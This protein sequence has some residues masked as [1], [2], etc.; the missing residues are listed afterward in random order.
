M[1]VYSWTSAFLLDVHR[2]WRDD[3]DIF[4]HASSDRIGRVRS[5]R[6]RSLELNPGHGEDRQ[7]DTFIL[8]LRYHDPDHWQDG[9]WDTFILPLSYHD[10]GHGEDRQW[11]TFILPLSYHDPGH[12]EDRQWDTFILPLI[13]HDPGHGE[14]RQW[15]TFSPPPE[16]VLSTRASPS[17]S[18]VYV[19]YM[20]SMLTRSVSVW[21]NVT[22]VYCHRSRNDTPTRIWLIPMAGLVHHDTVY[23]KLH[24]LITLCVEY[25]VLYIKLCG[26][27]SI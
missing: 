4:C 9:E 15:D 24:M 21:G 18:L 6:K 10:P 27:P 16:G 1:S 14:D 17:S 11:D 7:W 5:A 2:L 19:L 22:K 26:N 13:Y 23:F 12:G 20:A 25:S 3:R 8:P